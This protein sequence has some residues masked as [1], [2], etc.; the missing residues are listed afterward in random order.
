MADNELHSKPGYRVIAI[1]TGV[2]KGQKILRCSWP[3]QRELRKL[4]RLAQESKTEEPGADD[5][6][7]ESTLAMYKMLAGFMPEWTLV[8]QQGK[9]LPQP[10][11]DP[12]TFDRLDSYTLTYFVPWGK[13][14]LWRDVLPNAS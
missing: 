3:E 11:D 1:P 13:D 9:E 8:D 6:P 10:Q 7:G 5:T 2:Q 4:G 14:S 12:N